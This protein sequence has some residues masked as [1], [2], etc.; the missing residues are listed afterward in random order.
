M[1][2]MADETE[3]PLAAGFRVGT[4]TFTSVSETKI[5]FLGK[6]FELFPC[7]LEF[8]MAMPQEK[9]LRRAVPAVAAAFGVACDHGGGLEQWRA[10]HV[11]L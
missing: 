4:Q 11:S 7:L 10:C 9:T 1:E 3:L 2:E 8:H 6:Y 5:H